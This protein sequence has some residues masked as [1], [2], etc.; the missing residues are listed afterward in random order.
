MS[1]IITFGRDLAK[2][3]F[4]AHG[5]DAGRDL[6]RKKLRRLQALEFIA[7]LPACGAAI[8]A[9]GGAHFRGCK[10]GTLGHD[11]RLIPPADVQPFV[12]RQKP[13]PRRS[14]WIQ[15]VRAARNDPG[16]RFQAVSLRPTMHFVPVKS[17]E[18]QGAAMVCRL[19]GF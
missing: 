2:N 9:C 7:Q 19:R 6:L 4:Q 8:K 3:A 14:A 10:L 18:T 1:G 13:M 16:D 11:V 5:A 17:K 12:K 15:A